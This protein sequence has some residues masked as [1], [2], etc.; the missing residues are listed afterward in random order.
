MARI[1]RRFDAKHQNTAKGFRSHSPGLPGLPGY[2]GIDGGMRVNPERVAFVGEPALS[3]ELNPSR[4]RVSDRFRTQGSPTKVGQPWALL[5]NAFSVTFRRVCSTTQSKIR[6]PKSEIQISSFPQSAV[7]IPARRGSTLTE[8]LIAL[9]I[10]SIG[11]VSLAVLFP[12]SVLRSIKASQLTNATDARYN[13]EAAIDQFP[14][15][16]RDPD[17]STIT[18][19]VNIIDGTPNTTLNIHA[20]DGRYYA[21]DPL[22]Y[23]VLSTENVALAPNF[24]NVG[25]VTSPLIPR[26]HGTWSTQPTADSLVTL[27]DSWVLQYEGIGTALA[28]T[29]VNVTGLGA[30]KF[31]LPTLP[32]GSPGTNPLTRAVIFSGD[33]TFSQTRILTGV[34][35]DTI[36]WTDSLPASFT[37]NASG[38][39]KVRIETQERRYT[40]MLTVRKDGAGGADVYVVVFFQRRFDPAID[41]A[42]YGANF[43][44]GSTTVN[45]VTFP[46]NSNL[47]TGSYV[48]DVNN[49]FWYRISNVNVGAKTITLDVPANLSSP[50]GGGL[51][52]YPRNIVDVYPIGTK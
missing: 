34:A 32:A 41:E 28:A 10:M 12:M 18:N 5:R 15:I 27:P 24:G 19:G 20:W 7:R 21:F 48:L 16:V 23:A 37:G 3:T 51:A 40:W 36:S 14:M 33:G 22:G 39:G 11:L 4:V 30:T 46:P 42:M 49:C 1:H 43:T 38:V 13:A 31:T 26:C 25:G 17:Y 44:L 50:A 45:N 52:M 47:K 9:L 6:N 35:T 29:Q 8:V 2:P